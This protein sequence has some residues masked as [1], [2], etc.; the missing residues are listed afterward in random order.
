LAVLILFSLKVAPHAKALEKQV[1]SYW[2][3]LRLGFSYIR[4]HRLVRSLFLFFAFF[5]ILVSPSAFLTPLQVARSFGE[6][7]WRLTAIEVAFS[8]GMMLGGL[9]MSVW[10]GFK[11]GS[12]P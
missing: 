2:T 12:T 3:D 6:D 11:T 10:G 8:G 5:F 9:V 7:V 4:G 1:L